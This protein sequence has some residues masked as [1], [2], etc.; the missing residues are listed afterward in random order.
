[1]IPVYKPYLPKHITS[2]AHDAIDSSW[3]SSNGEYLNKVIDKIKDLFDYNY[4]LLTNNGTSAG[5]LMA[6]AL[7][8]LFPTKQT[9]VVPNNVYIAAWNVFKINP[10]FEFKVIDCDVDTWCG[11]YEE[12]LNQNPSD[13]IILIV[14]N[15]N[16]IVNVEQL[17][18]NY[19]D[20]IFIEDN[21]EGFL[22]KYDN[23]DTGSGSA[24][25]TISFYGNKNITSGEGG[26]LIV[27]DAH[28]FDFINSIR[29]QGYTTEKFIFDKL[30][31]NY[32]MTNIQA[33][34][35][36]GQLTFLSE[37]KMMKEQV[38][39]WYRNYLTD[40]DKIKFQKTD[41]NTDTS[42]WMVGVQIEQLT[43]DDLHKLQLQLFE[44]GIETRRM[45]PPITYHKHYSTE[46]CE[47]KNAQK[48]Y[49]TCLILPSYPELNKSQISKICDVLK[50]SIK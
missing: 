50:Q 8:N 6:I 27:N 2:Y 29:C 49:D 31:Y 42:N 47:I 5:H 46:I 26:A 44:N 13:N 33:A 9:I 35:L 39:D 38:F 21:C 48:V 28:T 25:S 17:K 16:S 24:L 12:Y 18:E 15:I 37:I 43:V 41:D 11:K 36:Y 22:G 30:G 34:L 19:P 40:S 20:N 3:V 10:I 4:V 23:L 14:H 32:R 7:N 45:F 1:M